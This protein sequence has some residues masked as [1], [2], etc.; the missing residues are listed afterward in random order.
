MEQG[1]NPLSR[2][3]REEEKRLNEAS[4][5]EGVFVVTRCYYSAKVG[6]K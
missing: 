2:E 5:T 1:F 4:A 3:E 6:D